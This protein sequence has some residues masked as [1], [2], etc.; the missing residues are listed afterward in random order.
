MEHVID[1]QKKKLGRVASEAALFLMGKNKANFKRN[2]AI[3]TTVKI[4]NTS[5]LSVPISKLKN[6][7]YTRYT[8]YPGGLRISKMEKIVSDKGYA[9]VMRRAV[10]GMLPS[11]KLRS[12]M[13]KNLV[14]SE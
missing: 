4:I 1:A 7:E 8:G 12:I 14:V 5:K 13:M 6:K 9:E 11:N 2:V 10:Y 3:E